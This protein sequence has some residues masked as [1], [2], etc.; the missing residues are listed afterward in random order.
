MLRFLGGMTIVGV[1]HAALGVALYWGLVK[2]LLPT[3][4]SEFLVFTMPAILAFGAYFLLSWYGPLSAARLGW[5]IF[6]AALIAFLALLV[7][8]NCFAVI[9]INTWGS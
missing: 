3:A 9:A 6:L 5:R 4:G 1:V 8:F 2:G 7:S